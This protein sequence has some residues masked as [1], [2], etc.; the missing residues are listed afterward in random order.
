MKRIVVI[1]VV[2][3][4]LMLSGCASARVWKNTQSNV[5]TTQKEIEMA[6]SKCESQEDVSSAHNKAKTWRQITIGTIL[7]PFV[8][9]GMAVTS[10][11]MIEKYKTLLT[12]CM[13][14]QGYYYTEVR[15]NRLK[16][17]GASDFDVS[18]IEDMSILKKY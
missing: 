8:N 15:S 3:M 11:S 6:I 17:D 4:G 10:E 9:I 16:W 12:R 2:T 14:N 1:V 13:K 7:I 5:P 18:E